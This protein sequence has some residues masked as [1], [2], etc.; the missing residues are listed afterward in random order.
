MSEEQGAADRRSEPIVPFVVAWKR[1]LA[2]Q[3]AADERRRERALEEARRAAAILTERFGVRRVILFGSLAW[4]RFTPSS[5]IDLA[6]DGLPPQ[7]F[8]RADAVLAEVIPFAV[9]LKLLSDCPPAL[10]RRIEEEGLA[11][12]E[13]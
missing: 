1:R 13:G 4:R 6:V 2:A 12:H 9:D 5:D 11:L 8:F 7:K 10:R 3:E